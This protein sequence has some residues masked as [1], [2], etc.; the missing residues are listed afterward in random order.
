M[1]AVTI[2]RF[3]GAGMS[4]QTA[5]QL[6]RVAERL[7]GMV[8]ALDVD[9][10]K[11]LITDDCE[12]VDEISRT[13][14]RGR[15]AVEAYFEEVLSAIQDVHTDIRDLAVREWTDTG[16]I[17]CVID[18]AY[19]YQGR[20]ERVIAPTTLLARREGDGWRIALMHTVP[21]PDTATG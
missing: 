6:D 2:G 18:Q 20:N 3:R 21:V 12:E 17:T 7:F 1:L 13:W 16:V 4:Q 19:R 5:V 9:G 15:A 14:R 11:G 10:I 8:D